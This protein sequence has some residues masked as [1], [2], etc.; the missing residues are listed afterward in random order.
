M[1]RGM[2]QGFVVSFVVRQVEKFGNAIDWEKVKDDAE[3][4]V[5]ALVPGTWFDDMA[6]GVVDSALAT[7]KKAL[8]DGD[9]VTELLTLIAG[10]QHGEAV[11]RLFEILA[12]E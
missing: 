5:R 12:A 10:K 2:V 3:V 7:L 11:T 4:R 9:G 8:T 1:I 6:V